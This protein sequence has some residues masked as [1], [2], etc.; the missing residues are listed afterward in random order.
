M[1][2]RGH[3]ADIKEGLRT[4]S[5][6]NSDE[7]LVLLSDWFVGDIT[8]ERSGPDLIHMSFFTRLGIGR[9]KEFAEGQVWSYKTR[10]GEDAS[11]LRIQKVEVFPVIGHVFHISILDVRIRNPQVDEG[12][13]TEMAHAPVSQQTLSQSCTRLVAKAEPDERYLDGY[14]EWRRAFD[15]G[16]AG[17]FTISVAEIVAGIETAI[18]GAADES[19]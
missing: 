1:P 12:V 13:S 10:L 5:G 14:A 7:R 17:V 8:L 3:F 16:D 15:A 11:T 6:G 9:G 19:L 4:A 2:S 18:N